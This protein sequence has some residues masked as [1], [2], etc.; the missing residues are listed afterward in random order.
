MWLAN[1][2]S[3]ERERLK[4]KAKKAVRAVESFHKTKE[5]KDIKK[6][7]V[8][9]RYFSNRQINKSSSNFELI[10]DGELV[11]LLLCVV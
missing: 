3:K 11:T 2:V 8:P 1:D 6:A 4:G 7:K 9:I 5:A 10:S